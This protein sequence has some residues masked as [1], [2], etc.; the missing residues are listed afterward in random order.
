MTHWK[1]QTEVAE[2]GLACIAVCLEEL[3]SQTDLATLRKS[4]P[5][6]QRGLNMREMV[7]ICGCLDMSANAVRCEAER[8][9]ELTL[10][11]ILHWEF[12]HFVVLTG[13]IGRGKYR[14]VDPATG[15]A[16]ISHEELSRK[17][18]GIALEVGPA[19]RFQ[20]KKEKSPLNMLSFF[21]LRRG[22][23][24]GLVQAA[25]VSAFLQIYVLASP[26]FVQ[27]A[28]DEAALKGD[29]DLLT[30]LAIGFGLFA[31]FNVAAE[32]LRGVVLQRVSSLLGWD[33]TMRLFRHMI[34]LPLGW[35]HRRRLADALSRF[36]SIEPLR[37]LLTNGLVAG[38]FDGV[39][40]IV[41]AVVMLVY[42]PTLALI[43]IC[44]VTLV[45]VLKLLTVRP[46]IKYAMA[47]LQASIAEKGKRIETLRAMQAIKLMGGESDRESDWGNKFNQYIRTSQ[48]A[49]HFQ[50]GVKACQ[51][52]I[53]NVALVAVV[54]A[55]ARS[56][57][58][59][60]VTVGMLYAFLSY[61]Q[62]FAARTSTLIDQIIAWRMLDMH[63]DRLAD[64]ALQ[65]RE[66]GIDRPA[67][68]GSI[69]N[70]RISLSNVSFRYTPFDPPILKSVNLDIADGELVMIV[71]Q[72]GSGKSTLLK[73]LTGLY[74]VTAGQV[75]Y[76]GSAISSL[77]P[78]TVRKAIGVVMQDDELLSGSITDNVAFFDEQVDLARVWKCLK[79]AA[80]EEDVAAMP[81]REDT[82]VGDMGSTLS[83]GQRQRLLLARALY[84]EPKVLIL[85]EA[86]S[87]LDVRREN[88]IHEALK[89]LNITRI[90]VSHRPSTIAIAD[91]VLALE[92]GALAP[93]DTTL[94]GRHMRSLSG[95]REDLRGATAA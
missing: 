2:C 23:G 38:I 87:N 79:M 95:E 26:F 12:N 76:D 22:A 90:V 74:P 27:L 29:L 59:G 34:R 53:E 31:L 7:D 8:M 19:P 68:P 36:D 57:V 92:N 54:Y 71:G 13:F 32:A 88:Q 83:G 56:L 16:T 77:G 42:S 55:G 66:D 9:R 18:T 49:A 63:S 15:E 3:G 67:V 82:L 91:R 48:S 35:F 78:R 89:A 81:M 24:S 21:D 80:L 39:L 44:G 70:G 50:I 69:A 51:S 93:L 58:D 40:G 52:L 62:Q 84:R 41:L 10:P 85:D 33:M 37:T 14:I 45:T 47:Q 65:A 5:V 1:H 25:C 17:F 86:T 11:A 20:R 61:R 73:V 75:L 72:S 43:A 64:I 46:S 60:A 28:V 94:L 30:S 4:F 6:S